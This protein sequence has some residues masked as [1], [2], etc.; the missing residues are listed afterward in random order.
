MVK[1]EV[2]AKEDVEP[3]VNSLHRKTPSLALGLL[4]AGDRWQC[5]S[6]AVIARKGR[7]IVGIA[8]I[9]PSGEEGSGKP[10]I[11]A[12]YV[13]PGFRSKGIGSLLLKEA[14]DYMANRGW[15]PIYLDILN[16]KVFRLLEK[17]PEGLKTKI[18]VRDFT[19]GG[20][21]DLLLEN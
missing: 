2:V 4:L 21:L 20:A 11:V 18:V 19:Q 8:T 16:S 14:I 7:K 1:I 3:W 17:L 9:A 6:E 5:V 10:T 12:L 13:L 15:Q